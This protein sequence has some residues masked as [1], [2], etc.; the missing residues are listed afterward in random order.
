MD[1]EDGL[2]SSRSDHQ[3]IRDE[4]EIWGWER[5]GINILW[6]TSNNPTNDGNKECEGSGFSSLCGPLPPPVSDLHT[7]IPSFG[8]K[9]GKMKVFLDHH[10]PSLPSFSPFDLVV[11]YLPN[12]V[13]GEEGWRG[14]LVIGV[15]FKNHV[16]MSYHVISKSDMLICVVFVYLSPPNWSIS[17]PFSSSHSLSSSSSCSPSYLNAPTFEGMEQFLSPPFIFLN[18]RGEGRCVVSLSPQ[19]MFIWCGCKYHDHVS[20]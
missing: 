5:G 8:E 19:N 2:I 17:N 7:P 1:D 20:E 4:E 11:V 15:R 10:L 12:G 3:G 16:I 13:E 9:S 6:I 14:A 18:W